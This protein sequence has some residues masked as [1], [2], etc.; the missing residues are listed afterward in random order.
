MLMR[1]HPWRT[2]IV[3]ALAVLALVWIVETSP[4][5]KDC[6]NQNKTEVSEQTL[7]QR[8]SDFFVALSRRQDCLWVLVHKNEGAIT[9][10]ATLLIALFT[11][12]LWRATDKMWKA[13]QDQ[14][15]L[16]RNIFVA[17]E[18]PWVGP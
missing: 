15:E 5:F 12:T 14:I 9:A 8:T 17:T 3:G 13:S 16:S 2:W 10:L 1:L 18:R 4:T 6:T 11:L 7:H